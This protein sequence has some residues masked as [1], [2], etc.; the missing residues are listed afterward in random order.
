MVQIVQINTSAPS[1]G[2]PQETGPKGGLE[3][4]REL[5]G[6]EE[7]QSGTHAGYEEPT[8]HEAAVEHTKQEPH[9]DGRDQR[10]RARPDQGLAQHLQEVYNSVYSFALS[11]LLFALQ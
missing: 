2:P 11:A 5:R 6:N 7:D 10:G 9:Q 1:G 4:E 3:G 8:E